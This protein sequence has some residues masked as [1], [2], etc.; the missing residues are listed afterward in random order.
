MDQHAQDVNDDNFEAMLRGEIIHAI[1]E[2]I[3]RNP[4][5]SENNIIKVIHKMF[6]D[7]GVFKTRYGENYKEVPNSL[8]IIDRIQNGHDKIKKLDDLLKGY[9]DFCRETKKTIENDLGKG[10]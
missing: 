7:N 5:I 6:S 1:F 10:T 9:I 8:A 4:N 2:Q 3:I